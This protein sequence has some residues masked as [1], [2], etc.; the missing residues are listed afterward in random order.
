MTVAALMHRLESRIVAL[1]PVVYTGPYRFE[2]GP[3]PIPTHRT[4]C[5]AC[6]QEWLGESGGEPFETCPG[7]A[8]GPP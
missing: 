2:R 5:L 4:R 1:S 6:G 8:N 3:L 7:A